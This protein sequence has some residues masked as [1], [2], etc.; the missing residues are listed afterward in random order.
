M[1]NK[2]KY[3]VYILGCSDNTLYVGHTSNIK[4]RLFWH[5]SGFASRHTSA[6]LPVKLVYTEEHPDEG[7]AINGENQ[8]KRWSG[9][10]ILALISDNLDL[11]RKLSKS[12]D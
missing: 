2:H 5:R 10:K 11:L 12:R 7:S 9:Q 3:Y 6:R 8:I 4:N 1:T